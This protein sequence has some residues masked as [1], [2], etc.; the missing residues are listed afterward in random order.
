[1]ILFNFIALFI[2]F[3]I[4]MLLYQRILERHPINYDNYEGIKK[5]LLTEAKLT[6]NNNKPILWIHIPYEYNARNWSSFGSRSSE[7]LNQPYLNLTVQ[8]II[9][10]CDNSFNICIIDDN[11]FQNLLPNWSIDMNKISSPVKDNIRRL[12]IAKLIHTYGGMSVPISFLCLKNLHE[13]YLQ[14][15]NKNT[16]FV[17]E[18]INQNITA[19]NYLFCPDANFIGANKDSNILSEY[20]E[21]IQRTISS[22]YSAELKFLGECDRWISNKIQKN[23]ITLIYGTYVGTKT[24]NS[25]QVNIE[26]LLGEDDIDFNENM[27]GIWIP[28]NILLSRRHYEWFVSL[29]PEQIFNSNFILATYFSKAL[30][31]QYI[32]PSHTNNTNTDNWIN[33][34]RVPTNSGPINIFGP[35]PLNLGN[36][37]SPV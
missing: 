13:L 8:S 30:D 15:T 19:S 2:I 3:I 36:N 11:T 31:K 37:I 33:F 18:N 34:W 28:N 20:I 14:G 5:Y 9:K 10:H 1:M 21:F 7:E 4:L 22:N 25:E 16:M 17:C 6:N 26:K 29:T 27:Y 12:G 32:K 35:K 24:I 23:K